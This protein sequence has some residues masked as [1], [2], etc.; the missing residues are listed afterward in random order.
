MRRKKN[1]IELNVCLYLCAAN[2]L[3]TEKKVRRLNNHNFSIYFIPMSVCLCVCGCCILSCFVFYLSLHSCY[4]TPAQPI[5]LFQCKYIFFFVCVLFEIWT[6][7]LFYDICC[8]LLCYCLFSFFY[9]L[10][11]YFEMQWSKRDFTWKKDKRIRIK[12][13]NTKWTKFLQ[14]NIEG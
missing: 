3:K 8:R 11:Y 2:K 12:C 4:C 13:K 10:C 9:L 1:E 7:N 14:L 6:E 5:A